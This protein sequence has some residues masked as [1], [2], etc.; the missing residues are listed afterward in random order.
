MEPRS[1]MD[2][3]VGHLLSLASGRS[4][5]REATDEHL[6]YLTSHI[7]TFRLMAPSRS[8]P[9]TPSCPTLLVVLIPP[10]LSVSLTEDE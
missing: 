2:R 10:V 5:I 6:A 8:V 7:T 4:G 1:E 9:P 3:R